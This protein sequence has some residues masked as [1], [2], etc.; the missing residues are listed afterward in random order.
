MG[1]TNDLPLTD[2]DVELL[3][4]IVPILMMVGTQEAGSTLKRKLYE[5][6]V[7]VRPEVSDATG[8]DTNKAASADSS[9]A[10]D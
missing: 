3:L 4:V 9:S 1:H 2:D 5:L 10:E 6:L 8:P 7:G